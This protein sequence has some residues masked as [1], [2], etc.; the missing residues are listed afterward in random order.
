VSY[1]F[2]Y[3]PP[4]DGSYD[5]S[6]NYKYEIIVLSILIEF[7]KILFSSLMYRWLPYLENSLV[8]CRLYYNADSIAYCTTTNIR[9]I[10]E[11]CAGKFRNERSWHCLGICLAG[12]RTITESFRITPV[13]VR[14]PTEHLPNTRQEHYRK[15]SPLAQSVG[16]EISG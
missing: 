11:Q 14:I 8:S 5:R 4:D 16:G 15:I 13:V 3:K 2:L 6:I 1:L 9:A 12:L 7:L 10:V